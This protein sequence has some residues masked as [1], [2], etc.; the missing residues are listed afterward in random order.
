MKK[1]R[2]FSG[3]LFDKSSWCIFPFFEMTI[4]KGFQHFVVCQEDLQ[5]YEFDIFC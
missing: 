3:A 1:F 2:S 5:K 4:A